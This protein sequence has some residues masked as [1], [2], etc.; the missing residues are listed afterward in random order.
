MSDTENLKKR[1]FQKTAEGEFYYELMNSYEL[2]PKLSHQIIQTAKNCLLRQ[3]QLLAGQIEYHCIR[4]DEKSG[5]ALDA[6]PKIKVILTIDDQSDDL[7]QL[8]NNGRPALRQSQIQRVAIE[9]VEQNGVLSQEDL[10]RIF[11]VT[12]RTIKRDLH[13]IRALGIDV[14]T[15]GNYHNIGRGQTHKTIIINQ[16][17]DGFTYSEISRKTRHSTAAIKRYMESF[18]KILMCQSCGITGL[19]EIKSLT[20]LSVFVISQYLTIISNAAKNPTRQQNLEML[21]NQLSFQYGSKKT[22]TSDGLRAEAT[23]GGWK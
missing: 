8:L 17:L 19:S 2:S 15:R 9:A 18:G 20:G 12:I 5:K 3:T 21:K 11:N 14:I 22:I 6:M 10:G 7:Q 13:A 4:L 1:L 23:T 16:H